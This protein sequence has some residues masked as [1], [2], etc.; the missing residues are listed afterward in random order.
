MI[1]SKID[2]H[3][4]LFLNW[5]LLGPWPMGMDVGSKENQGVESLCEEEYK[6][7]QE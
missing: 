1:V 3:N 6:R 4:D 2:M 5:V 7:K